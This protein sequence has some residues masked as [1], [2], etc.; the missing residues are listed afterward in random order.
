MI[1]NVNT[2]YVED[3]YQKNIGIKVQIEKTYPRG[4]ISFQSVPILLF[5]VS[6]KKGNKKIIRGK[7][8]EMVAMSRKGEIR[9]SQNSR[10][11]YAMSSSAI[12]EQPIPIV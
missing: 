3:T 1:E 10:V 2:K 11:Q 7:N 5:V 8:H 4:I 9:V 6:E 12:K